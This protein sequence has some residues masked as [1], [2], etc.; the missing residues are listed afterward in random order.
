MVFHAQ[1]RDLSG[2]RPDEADAV[3]RCTGDGIVVPMVRHPVN[4]CVFP[5]HDTQ[6]PFS[7]CKINRIVDPNT[8]NPPCGLLRRRIFDD[9]PG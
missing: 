3:F 1:G 6:I 7:I 5:V 8:L 2:Q 9:V 4:G